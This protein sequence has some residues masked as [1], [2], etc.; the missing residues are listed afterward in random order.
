MEISKKDPSYHEYFAT[1]ISVNPG[2]VTTCP[3][4]CHDQVGTVYEAICCR[5]NAMGDHLLME[6]F[7]VAM[8]VDPFTERVYGFPSRLR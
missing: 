5:I 2:L 8:E 1:M 7:R 3:Y 6:S 4:G